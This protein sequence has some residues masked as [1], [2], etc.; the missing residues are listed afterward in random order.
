MLDQQQPRHTKV[1]IFYFFVAAAFNLS[2]AYLAIWSAAPG[3]DYLTRL[4][5]LLRVIFLLD[6]SGLVPEFLRMFWA[7]FISG[8]ACLVAFVLTFLANPTTPPGRVIY[9]FPAAIALAALGYVAVIQ[10]DPLLAISLIP[11]A[12]AYWEYRKVMKTH[13]GV[14]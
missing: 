12:G 14:R 2:V 10:H 9:I 4:A 11:L 13:G 1:A 7:I 8:V 5:W 3:A 6:F